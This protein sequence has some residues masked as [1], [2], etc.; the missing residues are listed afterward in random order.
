MSQLFTKEEVAIVVSLP[1]PEAARQ[2]SP[3][4]TDTEVNN[5]FSQWDNWAQKKMIFNSFTVV[6]DYNFGAQ[7]PRKG[8]RGFFADK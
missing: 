3:T 2:I 1:S 8:R 5:C 7:W 4:S 6:N